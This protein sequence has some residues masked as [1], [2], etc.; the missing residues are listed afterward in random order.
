MLFQDVYSSVE[1]DVQAAMDIYD[2]ELAYTQ[3]VSDK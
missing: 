3:Q 1:R 2:R